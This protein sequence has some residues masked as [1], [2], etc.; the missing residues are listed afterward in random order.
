MQRLHGRESP[1]R[2]IAQAVERDDGEPGERGVAQHD[3]AHQPL[4][5]VRQLAAQRG[6]DVGLVTEDVRVW[7]HLELLLYKY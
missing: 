7:R 1:S 4:A 5:P 3:Q 6:G 2:D